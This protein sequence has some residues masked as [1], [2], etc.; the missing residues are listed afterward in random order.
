MVTQF[1]GSRHKHL[2]LSEQKFSAA[3]GI[4]IN[5]LPL[6][7]EEIRPILRVSSI[8]SRIYLMF[9]DKREPKSSNLR[10]QFYLFISITPKYIT[11]AQF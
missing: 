5:L 10:K 8:K 2:N 1:N 4:S 3:L 6:K 11:N 7:S 9:R